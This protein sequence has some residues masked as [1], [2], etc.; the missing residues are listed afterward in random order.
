M[1]NDVRIRITFYTWAFFFISSAN[2]IRCSALLL[3]WWPIALPGI[4]LQFRLYVQND[5]DADQDT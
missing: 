1:C 2:G 3:V 5:I 4:L